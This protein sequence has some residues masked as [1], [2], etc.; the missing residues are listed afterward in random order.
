MPLP[1]ASALALALPASAAVLIVASRRWPNLREAWTILA[2][3]GLFGLVLSL[4]PG[5]LRGD[6]IEFRLGSLGESMVLELRVD[7]LGML[8]ALLASF[9]WIVTSV[10]AIGYV[11]GNGEAH[12]TRFFAAF[13]VCLSSV[14]GLA[15]S[16]NLF[17]FFVFYELLTIATYPLVTHKG[18]DEARAA[19]RRYFAYLL[20]GG[21]ALLLAMAVV[22]S[23]AGS[24]DFVAGGFAAEHLSDAGLAA[25]FALFVLGFGSKAAIIPLHRWLPSAMVAP[26]PVSA[27]LHAV[28]VVKAGVFGFARAIGYVLGPEPL[29]DL[30]AALALSV[31]AAITIV[32]AS[33]IAIAQD[34]IKRRLAY[35]TIA[36]LSYIVLGLS[37]VSLT[38][39]TGALLHIANHAAL[40]ITLFF[41][42][43]ALY[44]HLRIDRVS[45]LDGVGRRMPVTMGAFALASLGLAGLPPMGGFVSKWYLVLGGVDAGQVALA[46]VMLF[47]GILTASYLFPI[48]FRAFLRPLPES[49]A[50]A[51]LGLRGEASPMMVV[52]IAITAL[53]G[54]S[55]G[56]GD[57][58]SVFEL[59]S[60]NAESVIG[61]GP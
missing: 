59:A 28:A 30:G 46:G 3:L 53:L 37:L 61:G 43:G 11:R 35:S 32:V 1:T 9:L 13:A 49:A 16:A 60:T 15:F 44:V 42:A 10:Y 5:V 40:K 54:L 12:Q 24:L 7:E 23:S 50:G 4:L 41:V 48:V 52:P 25:V 56:F 31:L 8:F 6:E 19:G 14:I 47:S 33:A 2:S 55:L 18:N 36:H 38:S 17:T 58:F 34:Q 57:L 29:S 27:L 51:P 26:T 21:G 22:Q 45:Q 20:T 39:W